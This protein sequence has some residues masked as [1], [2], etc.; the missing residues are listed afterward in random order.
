MTDLEIF[1]T[2]VSTTINLVRKY[3]RQNKEQPIYRT[4]A[5]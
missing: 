5:L 2:Q 1:K 4:T 3:H